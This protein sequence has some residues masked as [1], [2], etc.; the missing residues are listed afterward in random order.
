MTITINP[1]RVPNSGLM[2][3]TDRTSST[4]QILPTSLY[5]N[6]TNDYLTYS[7]GVY[8]VSTLLTHYY[9]EY[10]DSL[11]RLIGWQYDRASELAVSSSGLR[12]LVESELI[13]WKFTDNE[14]S[15]RHTLETLTKPL[16]LLYTGNNINPTQNLFEVIPSSVIPYP[17]YLRFPEFQ[18]AFL[19]YQVAS[20]YSN[21]FANP[22]FNVAHPGWPGLGLDPVFGN[23]F[24]VI[25]AFN[26]DNFFSRRTFPTS[27][28]GVGSGPKINI[29]VRS[30]SGIQC[31][32]FSKSLCLSLINLEETR[33]DFYNWEELQNWTSGLPEPSGRL[34]INSKGVY[35][36]KAPVAFT[37][38]H[39]IRQKTPINI[40]NNSTPAN[41]TSVLTD[42]FPIYSTNGNQISTSGTNNVLS[43]TLAAN[44]ASGEIV[45]ATICFGTSDYSRYDYRKLNNSFEQISTTLSP[46]I[47][48]GT[49][50]PYP[51]KDIVVQCS[52]SGTPTY[53]FALDEYNCSGNLGFGGGAA[54]LIF[55]Q[56]GVFH[57][58]IRPK[59]AVSL[60][61]H[62]I[63]QLPSTLVDTD[64]LYGF[65]NG[66]LKAYIPNFSAGIPASSVF[67]L[68]GITHTNSFTI[69]SGF[70][71]MRPNGT[72]CDINNDSLNLGITEDLGFFLKVF[73]CFEMSTVISGTRTLLNA[74]PSGA[75]YWS[76]I[77][78]TIPNIQASMSC[79]LSIDG[80]SI[81]LTDAP[82]A[83]SYQLPIVGGATPRL[84][85]DLVPPLP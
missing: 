28:S 36:T 79:S 27:S 1:I 58:E 49:F 25:S 64:P 42:S 56:S 7:S 85:D 43:A 48:S 20:G 26:S 75:P 57:Y 17:Q 21:M 10:G 8:S 77:R 60:G 61:I 15:G 80:I 22:K 76:F 44:S 78:G 40:G 52:I 16:S 33:S 63:S 70:I 84:A 46:S 39:F 65:Q 59:L 4:K 31:P 69:P 68:N 5:R 54:Q 71:R 82:R 11:V 35:L 2:E 45:S 53:N 83:C 66:G 24:N 3:Y 9:T 67:L 12:S 74:S 34:G 72:L 19:L 14:G 62:K 55:L 47:S 51:S 37:T 18:G 29:S 73:G 81:L 32:L 41:S 30:G 13:R 6:L 50:R 23:T 38:N